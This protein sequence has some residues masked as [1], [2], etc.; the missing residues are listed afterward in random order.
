M[1]MTMISDALQPLPDAERPQASDPVPGHTLGVPRPVQE[2]REPAVAEGCQLEQGLAQLIALQ[3][4]PQP[5]Q[6]QR[7]VLTSSSETARL[8]AAPELPPAQH[9]AESSPA[10]VTEAQERSVHWRA[11]AALQPDSLVEAED[12]NIT[13]LGEPDRVVPVADSADITQLDE[14]QL[15]YDEAGFGLQ[16]PLRPGRAPPRHHL[17]RHSLPVEVRGQGVLKY[18]E[19]DNTRAAIRKINKMAQRELQ[20]TFAKVY[21]VK[22]ASNNNNWLR[23]KLIEACLPASPAE[24]LAA[25]GGGDGMV[26]AA[27]GS[28]PL[29]SVSAADLVQD[30][31]RRRRRKSKPEPALSAPAAGAA[32]AASAGGRG[33]GRGAAGRAATADNSSAA[34]A[35]LA[36]LGAMEQGDEGSGLDPDRSMSEIGQG[37][38]FGNPSGYKPEEGWSSQEAGAVKPASPAASGP[39]AGLPQNESSRPAESSQ[40]SQVHPSQH[41]QQQQQGLEV[42][43]QAAVPS[44]GAAEPRQRSRRA[45]AVAAVAAATAAVRDAGQLDEVASPLSG[46]SLAEQL[47]G[48]AGRAEEARGEYDDEQL[49]SYEDAPAGAAR[50]KRR[51]RGGGRVGIASG[52]PGLSAADRGGGLPPQWGLSGGNN[53]GA[54]GGS[55]DAHPGRANGWEAPYGGPQ[56]GQR[57][58]A[59]AAAAGDPTYHPHPQQQQQHRQQQPQAQRHPAA[60]WGLAGANGEQAALGIDQRPN[61]GP[62]YQQRAGYGAE[63]FGGQQGRWGGQQLPGSGAPDGKQQYYPGQQAS[64]GAPA[65]REMYAQQP[66]GSTW[67]VGPSKL[68]VDM[69][70]SQALEVVQQW[71]SKVQQGGSDRGPVVSAQPPPPLQQQLEQQQQRRSEG[72]QVAPQGL[73][74]L[75]HHLRGLAGGAASTQ[76][77]QQQAPRAQQAAPLEASWT[78]ERLLSYLMQAEPPGGAAAAP[79]GPQALRAWGACPAPLPP[80]PGSGQGA[81][82]AA[83]AAASGAAAAAAGAANGGDARPDSHPSSHSS[84]TA[85]AGAWA[86]QRGAAAPA[87][88]SRLG[89]TAHN[90]PPPGPP[91]QQQQQCNGAA[92]PGWQGGE[93]LGVAAGNAA[94]SINLLSRLVQSMQGPPAVGGVK[95]ALDVLRTLG[96]QGR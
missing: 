77:A 48:L 15:L 32:G 24:A 53:S 41:V 31:P 62:T 23:K 14:L 28:P 10:A 71:V 90:L 55:Y 88:A 13:Q 16:P 22:S 29:R 92:V 30:G 58:G 83:E 20:A 33:R 7:P 93:G 73:Q 50:R 3:H 43:G 52:R 69:S 63:A 27:T 26:L 78:R 60:Q 66:C 94:S 17:L 74:A 51:R 42:A 40:R 68:P 56:Q 18:F 9:L 81:G 64:Y 12:R 1:E 2:P 38:Q 96:L 91:Q 79:A 70:L 36:L 4:Q 87:D 39:W 59:Y 45:A 89:S 57:Q 37:N 19:C 80:R 76:Q 95:G 84:L 67:Q 82:G 5:L 65:S 8:S 11:G 44:K 35:L 49:S 86:A 25:I 75:V 47:T 46:A 21:G 34:E 61:G 85:A 6:Q 72:T 54:W